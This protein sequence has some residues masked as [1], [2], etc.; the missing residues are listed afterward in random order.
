MSES[1]RFPHLLSGYP[2]RAQYSAIALPPPSRSAF[3]GIV[4]M[5]C[6]GGLAFKAPVTGKGALGFPAIRF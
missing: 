5:G 6:L 4:L 3:R 2:A 1:K